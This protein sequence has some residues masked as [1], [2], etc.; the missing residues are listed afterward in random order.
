[1]KLFS[2]ILIS[3]LS[4]N[5]MAHDLEYESYIKMQEALASDDFKLA[6]NIHETICKKELDHYT[7]DYKDCK[8][9]FKNIEELRDSFK[10]LS[11]LFIKNGDKTKMSGL[12]KAFCPMAKANWI[13]KDGDLKNPYYGK[14]MLDCGQKIKE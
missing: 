11:E 8:K 12:T 4:L 10:Q 9:K 5:V 7:S 1:M 14:S 6:K 2:L 3:F 13:Q